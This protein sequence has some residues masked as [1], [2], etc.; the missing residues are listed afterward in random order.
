MAIWPDVVRDLTEA[1]RHLDIPDVTRW[2]A[3]VYYPQTSEKVSCSSFTT[4]SFHD[5]KYSHI[6]IIQKYLRIQQN[7]NT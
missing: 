6:L 3:K 7:L 2:L 1:G 5:F 4:T